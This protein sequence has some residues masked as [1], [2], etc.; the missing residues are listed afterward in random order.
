MFFK[1]GGLIV[2]GKPLAGRMD[3]CKMQTKPTIVIPAQALIQD[4]TGKRNSL[5]FRLRGKDAP[6][7]R[8]HKNRTLAIRYHWRRLKNAVAL[9]VDAN[10]N[11]ST[12]TGF[13]LGVLFQ[14]LHRRLPSLGQQMQQWLFIYQAMTCSCSGLLL[15]WKAL[16][17]YFVPM[18]LEKLLDITL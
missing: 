13:S 12:C 16:A 15:P 4:A 1:Q 17:F 7:A 5:D 18:L 8:A 11:R 2:H 9:P 6:R 14:N 10:R 3:L